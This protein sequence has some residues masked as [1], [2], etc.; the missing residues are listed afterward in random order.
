MLITHIDKQSKTLENLEV[1]PH[2]FL[3]GNPGFL[4]LECRCSNIPQPFNYILEI[5]AQPQYI[6]NIDEN[7][8]PN[9]H[10]KCKHAI[11]RF[12]RKNPSLAQ[13]NSQELVTVVESIYA[14]ETKLSLFFLF[15]GT[16]HYICHL[17]YTE[18]EGKAIL[19]YQKNVYTNVVLSRACLEYSVKHKVDFIVNGS[20]TDKL[21]VKKVMIYR[22]IINESIVNEQMV[23]QFTF[24]EPTVPETLL[25]TI[26]G[27]SLHKSIEFFQIDGDHNIDLV[28]LPPQ[29][30]HYLQP[31]D[32]RIFKP[33]SYVYCQEL[34]KQH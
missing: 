7:V 33:L 22:S 16:N 23:N 17:I 2:Y 18:K 28:Y 5:D 31:L 15:R 20:K 9:D 10:N 3:K 11:V 29:P 13:Y 32:V 1:F 26:G 34:D 24:T 6:S 21:T 4:S 30:T 12:G 19:A 8:L 25:L 14:D 27:N